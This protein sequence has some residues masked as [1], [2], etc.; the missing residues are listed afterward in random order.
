[1]LEGQ[2]LSFSEYAGWLGRQI[3]PAETID[4]CQTE[5]LISIG[6]NTD[7]R[8][9]VYPQSGGDVARLGYAY[10]YQHLPAVERGLQQGGVRRAAYLDW[11]F[12]DFN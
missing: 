1:M 6:K 2:K 10:Q 5:P 9:T 4:W 7:I 3:D 11:L 8:D 12:S